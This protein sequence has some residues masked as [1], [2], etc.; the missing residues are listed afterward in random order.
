MRYQASSLLSTLTAA[1]L[2][3]AQ[4]HLQAQELRVQP[5]PFSVWLDFEKLST[6][7]PPKVALPIW[8]ESVQSEPVPARGD[9][10]EQTA[11]RIRL[12][13]M[14]HLNPE[15]QLR[16]FFQDIA[17][18]SPVVTGWTETGSRLYES[19][20]LGAGLNLPSSATLTV[21]VDGLDYLD[22]TVPGDG[23]NVR[24][25]FAATLRKT[26][27]R[28]TLDFAETGNGDDPFG[29]GPASKPSVDDLYLYGRTRATLCAE[30]IKLEPATGLDGMLWELQLD[31]SPLAALLTFEVLGA[32]ISFPPEITVNDR[33]LGAVYL[34]LPDLADPGYRGDVRPL[35]REMRFQYTG[36][37]RCQKLI[38]ASALSSGLNQLQL[39]LNKAS[40]PV[41]VRAVE[42]QLKH[43]WQDFDYTVTAK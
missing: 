40:G 14:P 31:A 1:L 20:S 17:G 5:T 38:P 9:S 39:R 32:D 42:I 30:T 12:R 26:E 23:S 29:S 33:P 8:L 15:I 35:E 2:A 10:P 41:A 25:V 34:Q 16:V 3:I 6:P 36:W 18:R 11:F 4:P 28:A 37:M 27:G 22:V 19:P 7:N 43:H 21:P 13:R 24:G